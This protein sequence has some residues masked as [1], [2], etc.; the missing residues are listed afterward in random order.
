MSYSEAQ[1]LQDEEL[2][3]VPELKGWASPFMAF[4]RQRTRSNITGGHERAWTELTPDEQAR[5]GSPQYEVDVARYEAD[6]Q[7]FNDRIPLSP[8]VEKTA[9]FDPNYGWEASK[10]RFRRRG[11]QL[12][13]R[14]RK[15]HPEAC[16]GP[17]VPV[18][19]QPFRFLDLPLELRANVYRL[20]LY[21][22]ISLVQME[23]NSTA[24]HYDPETDQ[25][26]IDVRVFAVSKQVYEEATTTFFTHNLIQINLGDNLP[27][28]FRDSA[29]TSSS[30]VSRLTGVRV[31]P[32]C[33][34]S[35]YVPQLHQVMDNILENFIA[36]R[37]IPHVYLPDQAGLAILKEQPGPS[38]DR[39][40]PTMVRGVP[41]VYLPDQA[42]WPMMKDQSPGSS[43]MVL[44]TEGQ[45]QRI[46]SIMSSQD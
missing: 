27:P 43:D 12:W 17:V 40:H 16:G 39:L 1:L 24:S 45:R 9:G 42:G 23:T 35:W 5:F 41:H 44:G 8:L 37:G 34:E 30:L 15:D 36:L 10:E 26:P 29:Q 11:A 33:P 28:M 38:Y 14:Y 22:P 3:A 13:N 20:L 19:D 4:L 21:R 2:W 18:P 46:Q 6:V 25:G 32:F 7:A 31:V